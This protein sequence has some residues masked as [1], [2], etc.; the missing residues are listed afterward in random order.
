MMK[1]YK[2]E[3]VDIDKLDVVEFNSYFD[4]TV[5]TTLPWIN[6]I[7]KD[8]RAKPLIIRIEFNDGKFLGY[9]TSLII[10]KFGI[11]I[12]GSPFRGWSTCYMGIETIYKSEKQY[13]YK[14]LSKFL[15]KKI[16]CDYIEI[17]DRD[18]SVEQAKKCGFITL[19]AETLELDIDK[20]DEGI[21]KQMK[22][23]CRNFIRQF[24]RR[25][26]KLEMV[27]P[28]EKFAKEYYEQLKDVFAKQKLVPTYSLEKVNNLIETLK[29][30]NQLLCLRVLDQENKSIATSIF[31]GY[32]NKFFFWGGA[33]Y[34]LGQHYRPNEY[35]IWMAIKYWRD[36]GCK[37]FDMVGDRK[38]KKKFGSYNA[39]YATIIF[40]KYKFLFVLRNCAEYIYFRIIELKGK[41]K[42][43]LKKFKIN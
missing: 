41:I 36:H 29:D 39:Q 8:S 32:K 18:M 22:T 12:V 24:E 19:A 33:S 5:F 15:F 26:A 30:S 31:L 28:D 25:G 43:I 10:K 38:Y 13:V 14:E 34:R 27:A 42:N 16:K 37:I 1:R 20:D 35:M 9:F 2:F 23:D 11:K 7:S 6:F 3:I 4:K 40:V 21:F 17:T